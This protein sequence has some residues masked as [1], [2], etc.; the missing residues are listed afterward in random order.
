MRKLLTLFHRRRLAGE[1]RAP[2]ALWCRGSVLLL[3]GER[4]LTS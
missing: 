1:R 2:L 4:A 3:L